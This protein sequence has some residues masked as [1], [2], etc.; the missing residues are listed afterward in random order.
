MLLA[1]TASSC[2]THKNNVQSA[3]ITDIYGDESW[4]YTSGG[5]AADWGTL[6]VPIGRGDNR[7]LYEEARAWIGT[8][9]KYAGHS[10]YGTD[11]SGLVMEIYLKVYHRQLERNSAN[12]LKRNC[13]KI[14]KNDLREGDLVFFSTGKSGRVNHVGIYLRE[15]KFIHASSSRGVI[16]SDM[17]QDYYERHFVAAGRVN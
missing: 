17:S 11:C 15:G 4:G 9:Y 14:S 6:N 12:M 2:K 5:N 1:V 16:V 13:K 8:P 3:T 10:K 7:R